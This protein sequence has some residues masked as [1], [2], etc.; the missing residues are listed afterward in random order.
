[1]HGWYGLLRT[2]VGVDSNCSCGRYSE[3]RVLL[4]IG[5][6]H[7]KARTNFPASA[8]ENPYRI[9]AQGNPSERK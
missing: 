6:L 7:A 5:G 4:K 3:V 9:E 1:M 2:H 8:R